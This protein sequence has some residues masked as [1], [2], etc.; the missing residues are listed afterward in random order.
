MTDRHSK[1]KLPTASAA[2]G[3]L[4]E[5]L[6]ASLAGGQIHQAMQAAQELLETEPGRGT[7]RFLRECAEASGGAPAGLKPIKVALLSSFSTEFLHD[8]LVAFGFAAGLQIDIYQAGFGTFRQELLNPEGAL[9]AAATD[10]VILAV[11]ADDWT[12]DAGAGF[13]DLTDNGLEAASNRF[14]K[15]LTDLIAAFRAHS[16]APLLVHNLA[17]PEWRKL[18]IFDPKAHNSHGL[19]LTRMNE[20]LSR[21]ARAMIDVHIVDCAALVNRHGAQN[22]YDERMRL[23]ARAPIANAMQPHLSREY[24]KFLAALTGLAKKCLVLDMDNTLWGGVVGEEGVDGIALGPTYPGNA[25]LEFQRFVLDLY[26]RGVIIAAASKNN[27][28]DVEEVFLRHPFMVLRKEHFAD[29]QIHW[30]PKSQSLAR[31]AKNLSIGLEHMVF[32]D[33]NAAECAEVRGALPMVHVVQLPPRPEGFVRSLQ[34]AGLFETLALSEEDRRRGELYHRRAQAVAARS[35]TMSVEDY[36]RSLEMELAIAPVNQASLHRTA[37]LTQKTSQ[38]NVTTFRYSEAHVAGRMPDPNWLQR[39]VAVKDRFGDH[40]IVGVLVARTNGG[41]MD[42]DTLLL[43]CRVIGRAI[44]TAM[45]AYLCDEARA[46]GLPSVKAR[47]I[48]TAKNMPA[49]DLFERH[50]FSRVEGAEEGT[51]LW[52]LDLATGAIQWPVWFSRTH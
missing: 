21:V 36:Y 20:A 40:G 47:V 14:E 5:K 34:E 16:N 29:L 38:F 48:H 45:L 39:T 50:G 2:S 22:W 8:S 7:H 37:Q 52:R 49:R 31:I 26:R 30:E 6:T 4:R 27:P 32:V 15:E 12:I 18:G 17:L 9:H 19:L 28:A 43:S 11:E 3:N 42:I 25:Y 41:E 23:Y 51:T 35:E 33:D 10:V 24:V 13:F 1:E 46:R 44:E